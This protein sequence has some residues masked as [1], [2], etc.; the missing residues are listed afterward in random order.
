MDEFSKYNVSVEIGSMY[1]YKD[2]DVL[3]NKLKLKDENILKEAEK[4]ITFIRA[5]ELTHDPINGRFGLTHLL[6]IHRYIFGDIYYFAGRLRYEDMRK[7]D[8]S[9]CKAALIDKHLHILFE[10]LKKENHLRNL[11]YDALLTRLAYY[12]AELN[13]IHPFREGNGR[14]IREFIRELALANDYAINWDKVSKQQLLQA[15]IDSIYD[16]N[17]LKMCLAICAEKL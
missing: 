15:S 9:F 14:A 11:N 10:E 16:I 2:A 13:R 1:Y 7:A 4:E 3:R 8:T 17:N 6:K 5:Y 12:M